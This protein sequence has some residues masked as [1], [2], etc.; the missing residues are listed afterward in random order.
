MTNLK[1][2]GNEGWNK[3]SSQERGGGRGRAKSSNMDRRKQTDVPG[4]TVL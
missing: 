3:H 1:K 2:E 4:D